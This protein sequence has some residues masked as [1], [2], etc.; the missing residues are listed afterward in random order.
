M[1]TMSQ[2]ENE[3][4]PKKLI[5]FQAVVVL[6]IYIPIA[7]LFDLCLSLLPALKYAILSGIIQSIGVYLLLRKICSVL[8]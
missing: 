4:R 5:Y 2:P 7:L 8:D 1:Q 3:Q 6:I